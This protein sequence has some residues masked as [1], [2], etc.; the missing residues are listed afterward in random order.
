MPGP[1]QGWATAPPE[2][3]TNFSGPDL[4]IENPRISQDGSTL[5]YTRGKRTGDIVILHPTEKRAK[6]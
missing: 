2:K 6:R 4:Y 5:V 1:A 3:V